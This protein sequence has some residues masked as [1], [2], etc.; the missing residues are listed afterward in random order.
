MSSKEHALLNDIDSCQSAAQKFIAIAILNR[1]LD[2]K[3]L[4]KEAVE[5]N[6]DLRS[7]KDRRGED[8]YGQVLYSPVH[9][10]VKD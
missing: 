10:L 6:P 7:H 3:N 1:W 4:K 8:I 2:K 9:L 5:I